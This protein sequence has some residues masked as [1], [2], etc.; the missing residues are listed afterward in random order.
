MDLKLP[1]EDSEFPLSVEEAASILVNMSS[2]MDGKLMLRFTTP[3]DVSDSEE[4]ATSG[5]NKRRSK[6]KF[7]QIPALK[8]KRTESAS[9]VAQETRSK[10]VQHSGTSRDASAAS[11]SQR[12]KA[13]EAEPNNI[14]DAFLKINKF[15]FLETRE[16]GKTGL[17]FFKHFTDVKI[18]PLIAYAKRP[19]AKSVKN[20]EL[21]AKSP[22]VKAGTDGKLM[23]ISEEAFELIQQC[24]LL[25]WY[26]LDEQRQRAEPTKERNWGTSQ[27]QLCSLVDANKVSQVGEAMKVAGMFKQDW[28]PEL[29]DTIRMDADLERLADWES[30]H[31]SGGKWPNSK[32]GCRGL[33]VRRRAPMPAIGATEQLTLPANGCSSRRTPATSLEATAQLTPPS[34]ETSSR[35]THVA[36]TARPTPPSS[37]TSPQEASPQSRRLK[38]K[39]T[40][41]YQPPNTP[42]TEQDHPTLTSKDQFG[43][44]PNLGTLTP[45]LED[46]VPL[47]NSLT[48]PAARYV[49]R[50]AGVLQSTHDSRAEE[51]SEDE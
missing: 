33:I 43:A 35:K 32:K 30:K 3:E 10:K 49:G 12:R 28:C 38:L 19:V 31:C 25:T 36:V 5:S 6:N 48:S 50:E 17:D 8:R 44:D 22:V 42:P 47:F 26:L 46:A 51:R 15:R 7:S 29:Y 4:A 40:D 34:S 37:G 27:W 21:H 16:A 14:H 23:Q 41:S 1:Q 24:L 2:S 39:G 45:Q 13:N 11:P 20:G 18:P 9:V